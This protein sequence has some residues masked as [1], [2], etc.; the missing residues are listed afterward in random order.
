MKR[1][2]AK[3]AKQKRPR[4]FVKIHF[5][6]KAGLDGWGQHQSKNILM[7]GWVVPARPASKWAGWAN[8]KWVIPSFLW[9]GWLGW[10]ANWLG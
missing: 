5:I 7:V 8:P 4:H 9:P 10:L 1:R 2:F 6:T 3:S